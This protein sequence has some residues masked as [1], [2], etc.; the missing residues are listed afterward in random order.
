MKIFRIQNKVGLK[1]YVLLIAMVFGGVS[2]LILAGTMTWCSTT[3][4][5]NERNNQYFRTLA[6]AEAATEKVLS[7]MSGD[8]ANGGE[9]VVFDRLDNYRTMVPD[10]S[11]SSIWNSFVFS[12]GM[13]NDGQ[14]YVVRL[15]TATVTNLD[16]EYSGLYGL[17][18]NYRIISNARQISL[19]Y[20]MQAALKQ[21]VQLAT[22]PIF[23]FAI[24]YNLDL[25]INNG[26]PMVI[27]GRVHGNRELYICPPSTLNFKQW[28]TAAGNVYFQ[29]KPGDQNPSNLGKV[30]F[31]KGWDQKTPP[32][33]MPVGTNNSPES[34]YEILKVPPSGE[35]ADSLMGKQRYYN[36][37]DLVILVSNNTVFAKSKGRSINSTNLTFL[38]TN[39]TFYNARE[40]KWVRSIDIDVSKLNVWIQTNS[41]IIDAL[42]GSNKLSSIY[43]ADM[44]T[45]PSTNQTGV[46]VKNGQTLPPKGLTV[47]TPSPIY[48][49]GHY[50]APNPGSTNTINTKPASLVGDAITILSQNWT[51]ANSDKNLDTYRKATPTTVNAAFLAGIVE[52]RPGPGYSGGV[53]NFPRFL[54][55]WSGVTFTY[56]GSMVVLF[57]SRIATNPWGT[58][59]AYYRVPTRSWWFDLN[60]LDPTKLPPGTPQ[61]NTVIR[62]KWAVLAPNTIE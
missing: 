4:R 6:A 44:R 25:E 3:V 18:S 58:T 31:E 50:N 15:S 2:A 43:V 47:A 40:Q 24:F 10:S 36:K 38:S 55:N 35:P 26:Q 1:S 20:E 29:R 60:F 54:E 41:D 53:E 56:N 39:Q 33:T 19:P 9:A 12:D 8:F 5:L 28:V 17:A 34:V 16:S 59:P 30:D 62:T 11:E 21:D 57:P 32:L 45:L 51:D 14:T 42:G 22:I 37:A 27:G 48:V 13:G 49:W 23:Q 46:R 61:V 7:R 52:T